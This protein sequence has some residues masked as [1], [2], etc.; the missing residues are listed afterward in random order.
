MHKPMPIRLALIGTGRWGSN[1]LKTVSLIPN[2]NIVYQADRKWHTLLTKQDIDG[3]IIATPPSTHAAIALP[4]IRRGVPVFIEKPMTLSVKEARALAAA[5]KKSGSVVFVGH[6]YLYNPA[7]QTAKKLSKTL[8]GKP[9]LLLSEAGGNGPQRSD[10][11]ALWDYGSHSVYQVLD[12]VGAMPI[13]VQAW[14]SASLRPKTTL[15]DTAQ[16]KLTFKNGVTGF[17]LTSSVLSAKRTRLTLV[18]AKNSVVYDNVLP[19]KKVTLCKGAKLSYPAYVAGAPLPFELQ[20]FVRTISKKT[21][22]LSGVLEGLAVVQILDAAE[23]S[24]RAKGRAIGL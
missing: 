22:P 7:Y 11:S 16:M 14:G 13:S 5:A 21:K 6:L 23:K 1:I 9:L 20:A 12:I 18:G 17:V 15:W 24:I 2:C 8:V 4:F 3:V 19:E 10:C